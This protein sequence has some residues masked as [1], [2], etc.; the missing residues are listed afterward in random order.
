MLFQ[1]VI[2][3]GLMASLLNV[4]VLA[5]EARSAPSVRSSHEN[6]PRVSAK[7][8]RPKRRV[9]RG[10]RSV[11]FVTISYAWWQEPLDLVGGDGSRY[12]LL[13]TAN[14]PCVGIG[15]KK[16]YRRSEFNSQ[17]CGFSVSNE[18]G[19]T[20]T[21]WTSRSNYYQQGVESYGVIGGPGYAWYPRSTK[22]SFGFQLPIFFRYAQWTLPP[23]GGYVSIDKSTLITGGI[24]FG[25]SY[26]A[27][28]FSFSPKIAYMVNMGAIWQ[29]EVGLQL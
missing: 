3:S 5:Q 26:V 8:A 13:A 19:K 7:P 20:G 23:R 9:K 22:V 16:I 18:V 25:M 2:L 29:M 28:R 24:Q 27:R 4:Q 6:A 10:H 14:G 17:I 15:W 12:G 1:T 21:M 11:W